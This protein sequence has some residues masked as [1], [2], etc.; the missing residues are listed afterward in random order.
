[1][2]HILASMSKHLEILLKKTIPHSLTIFSS[3]DCSGWKG[4]NLR[5]V[6]FAPY[7]HLRIAIL[8]GASACNREQSWVNFLKWLPCD[9]KKRFS[10]LHERIIGSNIWKGMVAMF[11]TTNCWFP[12]VQN[13]GL[14]VH[15]AEF[16]SIIVAI[17]VI[18]LKKISDP[19]IMLALTL[20]MRWWLQLFS[21]TR[22]ADEI[23]LRLTFFHCSYKE[24][25]RC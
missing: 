3:T 8:K 7:L 21:S 15:N 19:F 1:M 6:C 9:R 14:I 16:F 4:R 20:A 2:Y 12:C 10:N 11:A 17:F 23:S 22:R 5:Q 24:S 13:E 25:S 18:F